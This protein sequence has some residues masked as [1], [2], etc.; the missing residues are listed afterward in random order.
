[1]A[2]IGRRK[3]V[4][5]LNWIKLR[6]RLAWLGWL[7]VHVLLLAR[8]ENR[9]LVLFQWFFNYVTLNRAARLITGGHS[10]PGKETVHDAK[11]GPAAG[12]NGA[13]ETGKAK[14]WG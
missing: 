13:A 4:A 5:D 8:F 11:G 9:V 2:T 7:F 10:D 14:V 12:A 6:G 1:M 3:A